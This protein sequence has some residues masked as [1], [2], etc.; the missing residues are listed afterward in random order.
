[1]VYDTMKKKKNLIS[2]RFEKKL[3]VDKNKMTIENIAV[4]KSFPVI[5]V[6]VCFVSNQIAKKKHANSL[7]LTR[8]MRRIWQNNK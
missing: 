4:W 8:K 7:K 5:K 3:K 1:M 2:T 6:S